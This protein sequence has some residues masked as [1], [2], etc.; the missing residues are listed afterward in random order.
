MT[1]LEKQTLFVE[2]VGKFLRYAHEYAAAHGMRI[3]LDEAYRPPETAALYA[4]QGRGIASSLHT[5][6]LAIDLNLIEP[7]PNGRSRMASAAMYDAL[8]SFWKS[9]HELCCWGGDFRRPDARH[10]SITHGG[11]K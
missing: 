7:L 9:L 4:Q 2:T 6:K 3:S 10:F 5:K 11:V 1:L 8:G